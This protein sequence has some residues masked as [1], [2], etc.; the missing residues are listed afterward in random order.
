MVDATRHDALMRPAGAAGDVAW[1]Q[2]HGAPFALSGFPWFAADGVYR[3]L[4]VAPPLPLSAAVDRLADCTAGGT[5]RFRS[6]S[7]R[8]A[9]RVQLAGRAN[10]NHM[11]ATG[12]CGFDL[13]LGAP[14]AE[15]FA[16]VAKYDH[17]LLEYEANL[18]ALP[19]RQ[20]RDLTLHFPLYQGVRRVDIGLDAG[21]GVAAPVPRRVADPLVFYGSSITQGGC[22]SRPGMAYTAILAR[23]LQADCVNLGFSGNGRGEPE[24]AR[25]I[26]LVPRCAL[27]VLDYDPNCPDAAHLSRT[28]PA[29]VGILRQRHPQ[30]PILVVSR[31]P[32]AAEAWSQAAVA[33]RRERAAAQ[34]DGVEGLRAAGDGRIDFLD[35]GALLGDRFDECTVDGTHP[36]D[37]GF[38]R[39][40]DAL[41]P[42]LRRLLGAG[43]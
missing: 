23:Q 3:R 16:G 1:R 31:I 35:G 42:A 19:D 24:V 13:Y 38:L 39:M 33:S 32:T 25:A 26:A 2:A 6:D 10:M 43:V 22:A 7:G 36:T 11:P 8:V 12:Q 9:V 40:A 27:F 29:F 21:A 18:L 34:R 20:W 30:A 41:E 17:S 15:R 5:V 4:P 28:L 37:L 14:G